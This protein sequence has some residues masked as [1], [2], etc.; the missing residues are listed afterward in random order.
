MF[1]FKRKSAIVPVEEEFTLD[2]EPAPEVG[3]AAGPQPAPSEAEP[4]SISRG[5]RKSDAQGV[6]P[7]IYDANCILGTTEIGK[8]DII[9]YIK[10]KSEP[11]FGSDYYYGYIY[12]DG[13]LSFVSTKC[14]KHA[15]GKLSVFTPAFL[16]KGVFYYRRGG[17]FHL[18]TTE[19]VGQ[20]SEV[21]SYEKPGN[22][23]SLNIQHPLDKKSIPATLYL[24]WSLKKNGVSL[25]ILAALAFIVSLTFLMGAN[26]RYENVSRSARFDPLPPPQI[27]TLHLNP[28]MGSLVAKVAKDIAGRGIIVSM[29]SQGEALMFT[30]E[31]KNETEAR[32]FIAK[33]GSS[34]VYEN[35]K[36]KVPLDP[37]K[38]EYIQ[39][40]PPPIPAAPQPNGGAP[41]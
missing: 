36:V 35:G 7:S 10:G 30:I 9:N 24:K 6:L 40:G 17:A 5:R 3:T 37:A 32:A 41:K 22:A 14:S 16:C 28:D 39:I 4:I 27:K 8:K 34:A 1:G 20:T 31:F 11:L 21:I 38:N 2:A 15:A 33:A 29:R 26:N 18:L 12:K 25:G 13:H 19:E 23:I